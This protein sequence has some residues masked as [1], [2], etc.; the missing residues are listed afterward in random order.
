MP[1]EPELRA[2]Y[3][4]ARIGRRISN[5]MPA[6]MFCSVP[7][8]ARP[9]AR[10]AAPSTAI[11]LAVCTPKRANTAISVKMRT[12]QITVLW[13]IGTMVGSMRGERCAARRTQPPRSDEAHQ[14][15][16]RISNAT[17]R[18]IPRST[19]CG[20]R[21]EISFRV[22]FMRAPVKIRARGGAAPIAQTLSDT[23]RRAHDAR[24]GPQ[25]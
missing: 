11:R 15:R 22:S 24:A 7:C 21:V 4:P 9:T 1:S 13:N 23:P 17:P 25:G 10:P 12:V 18:L 6:A 8:R 2:T 3:S 14:P 16:M 5:M 20:I 19:S